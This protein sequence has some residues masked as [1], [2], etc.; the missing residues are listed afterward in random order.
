MG[1]SVPDTQFGAPPSWP[2]AD[3]NRRFDRLY[4]IAYCT[5]CSRIFPFDPN[6]IKAIAEIAKVL[7]IDPSGP[8]EFRGQI[9]PITDLETVAKLLSVRPQFR[10]TLPTVDIEVD[11]ANKAESFVH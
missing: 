4:D 3:L 2:F 11:L 5:E 6:F 8:I 9:G 1:F 10:T 7:P